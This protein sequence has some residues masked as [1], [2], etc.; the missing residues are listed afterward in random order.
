MKSKK[1]A[2][3]TP[4]RLDL[5]KGLDRH[6]R[7]SV[8][9]RLPKNDLH[10][11]CCGSGVNYVM[12]RR[13]DDH[14]F[15]QCDCGEILFSFPLGDAY[16]RTECEADGSARKRRGPNGE[17]RNEAALIGPLVRA[18]LRGPAS[19]D[20]VH[21]LHYDCFIAA[22]DAIRGQEHRAIA[23]GNGLDFCAAAIERG[24][25]ETLLPRWSPAEL[26]LGSAELEAYTRLMA[27][28]ADRTAAEAHRVFDRWIREHVGSIARVS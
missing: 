1:R 18:W 4:T 11:G 25:G 22:V 6:E 15:V 24:E 3:S 10:C 28:L 19:A 7:H 12:V 14:G 26:L 21:E 16:R 23:I 13:C 5:V 17:R 8:D 9:A 2:T 20:A 27:T